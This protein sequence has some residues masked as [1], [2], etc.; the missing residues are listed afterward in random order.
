MT[1]PDIPPKSPIIDNNGDAIT[2][3][4]LCGQDERLR[5]Q[6]DCS[7]AMTS[8]RTYLQFSDLHAGP[9]RAPL[10]LK[11]DY[12]SGAQVKIACAPSR[13]RVKG[14]RGQ[15]TNRVAL[16]PNMVKTAFIDYDAE[17]NTIRLLKNK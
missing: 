12:V 15:V 1:S 11:A 3:V 17:N 9:S 14:D 10:V 5:F 7:Q 16:L 8:G 2:A 4:D 13:R 6:I